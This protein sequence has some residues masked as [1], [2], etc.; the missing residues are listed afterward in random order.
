MYGY[1][2][3]A[4]Y[5]Q[6]GFQ[7]PQMVQ[8]MYIPPPPAPMPGPTVINI[9]KQPDGTKCPFC[10]QTSE[11]RAR[12]SAGCTTY[13]WCI[14]LALTAT[15]FFWIPFCVDGCK[16]VEL[17]CEKCGQTK[18]T[19]KANCCWCLYKHI[20]LYQLTYSLAVCTTALICLL[21]HTTATISIAS[22]SHLPTNRL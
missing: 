21:F 2:Q 14:C 20:K 17:V 22:F 3:P 8:P 11:N 10:G 15:P 18:N 6:V 1:S 16:D 7:Q 13:S 9:S 5:G 12:K 4:P 19:I